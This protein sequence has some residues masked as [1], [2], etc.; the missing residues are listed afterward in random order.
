VHK[1]AAWWWTGIAIK[2]AQQVGLHREP[3]NVQDV[4]GEA[5]QG[6]RRRIW[7]TLF[8]SSTTL[9][10]S[11]PSRA[12]R[13]RVG[14]RAIDGNLSRTTM[15]HQPKRLRRS[16]AVDRRLRSITVTVSRSPSRNFCPL[17]SSLWY[18]W[19]SRTT[20]VSPPRASFFPRPSRRRTCHLG[21]KPPLSSLSVKYVWPWTDI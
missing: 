2:Y 9:S 5:M 3:K 18:Y 20:F 13:P 16:R 12:E 6:L 17:G 1:D 4:G 10:K 15:Y 8:V 19:T 7:W 14:S 11:R 21:S